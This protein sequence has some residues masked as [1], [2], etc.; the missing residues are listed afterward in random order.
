MT[1][2]FL[3]AG[4]GAF[5][6][7]ASAP[8]PAAASAGQASATPPAASAAAPAG[9]ANDSA[10]LVTLPPPAKE[11]APAYAGPGMLQIFASLIVVLALLGLLAWGLRRFGPQHIQGGPHMRIVGGI[12]LGG[13]ERVLVLEVGEQWIVIG[14]APGRVSMLTTLPRQSA[15][16]DNLPPGEKNFANWLKQFMEKKHDA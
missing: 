15:P 14:A 7:P 9:A 1:L 4:H 13:R 10:R 12:S 5:A 3:L 16:A 2:C 11:P 6:N 8:P